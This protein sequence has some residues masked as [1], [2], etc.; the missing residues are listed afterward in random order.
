M[1]ENTRQ[2]FKIHID[3]TLDAVWHEITKQGEPQQCFFN[4]HMASPGNK[5]AV[6]SPIRMRN[7][8]GKYTG[9]IGEVLEFDPPRRYAHT[10]KF[11]HLDDPECKVIYDLT[12]SDS[13]GVDFQMT[14]D[15]LTPGT[16]TAKQMAQ[17]ASMIM[18][19]L[20]NMVE[21]GKPSFGTRML[22]ILFKVMEPLTPKKS[23]SSNWPF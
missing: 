14:L 9:A 21:R 6:G 22:Y 17:G 1:A 20:K 12:E 19:T 23:L 4:M 18:N 10:F 13:G 8:S 11:T 15:D 16:K 7:K 3:G 5:L 2:V